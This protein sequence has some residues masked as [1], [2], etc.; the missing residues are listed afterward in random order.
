LTKIGQNTANNNKSSAG[1]STE[2]KREQEAKQ[3]DQAIEVD[4]AAIARL[5]Q[6]CG[7]S[8]DFGLKEL[9][10]FEKL[11]LHR[12]RLIARLDRL[13]AT[14]RH[15]Q[16]HAQRSHPAPPS[17]NHH[18]EGVKQATARTHTRREATST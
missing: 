10:E 5:L 4:S 18:A 15:A 1:S 13:R 6:S 11:I 17:S 14:I 16:A 3:L 2:R 8:R 9:R 7:S 12:R